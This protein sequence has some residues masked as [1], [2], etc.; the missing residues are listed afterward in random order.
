MATSAVSAQQLAEAKAKFKQDGWAIVPDVIDVEKTKE[1]VDRLWKAKEESERRGDPTYLDWLDPNSSNVRI[2]YLMELDPIFRELI[3]HPVAV[4]MVQFALGQNFLVSNFT[5]NIALP[6]SK[7]M[8]LHSDLSLQCPDPWLSTW[9]LN[10]IW[11]LHD[12]YY[13]NGATLY[14]PGSHRWKTKAE[15]PSDEEA[16][17]LLVPFEAKAGSIIVMDGRLWHTSGC[18]IT[19][20]KQRALLFGAYNA[21][22]LRGQVNWSAGLSEETKKTLSPQLREWL[23]VNRDGNLGVVTGVND[24]FAEGAAPAA[25]A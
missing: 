14:I 6:G 23:G 1:V 10:V 21:P 13:K 7:S 9:G 4:E 25:H 2:F 15:V 20:D 22:F 19:E 18:N 17:K 16:R 12:V 8:G 5:A 3:S 11:C 24:V